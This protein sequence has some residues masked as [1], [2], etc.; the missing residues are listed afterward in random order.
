MNCTELQRLALKPSPCSSGEDK[1]ALK[2]LNVNFQGRLFKGPINLWGQSTWRLFGGFFEAPEVNPKLQTPYRPWG[3]SITETLQ[4]LILHR[5]ISTGHRRRLFGAFPEVNPD[6]SLLGRFLLPEVYSQG[7]GD[8]WEAFQSFRSVYRAGETLRGGAAPEV[9][10]QGKGDSSG[11]CS[12][13]GL[14]PGQGRLFR[15]SVAAEVLP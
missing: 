3:R 14:S 10:P 8:S 4:G 15:G 12:P 7:R 13:R 2:A 1:N 6:G 11:E 9:N 5:G